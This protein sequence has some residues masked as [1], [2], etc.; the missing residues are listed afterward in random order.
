MNDDK[1]IKLR[2]AGPEIRE[3]R[4]NANM[5]TTVALVFTSRIHLEDWLIQHA[6]DSY[7]K[8]LKDAQPELKNKLK[9]ILEEILK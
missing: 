1:T 6:Q 8:G 3:Q 4:D 5:R 9:A 7:E 2:I